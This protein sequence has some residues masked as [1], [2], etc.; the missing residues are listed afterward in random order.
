ME[1][2]IQMEILEEIFSMRF[3]KELVFPKIYLKGIFF[4]KC[5][6]VL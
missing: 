6:F 1:S 2:L 4:L 3:N 5:I